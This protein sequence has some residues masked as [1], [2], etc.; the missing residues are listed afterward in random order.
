M[1]NPHLRHQLH[2]HGRKIIA[3]G[4]L[5]LLTAP[6]AMAQQTLN[7]VNYDKRR[8]HYGFTLGIFSTNMHTRYSSA[9]GESMLVEEPGKDPQ[10]T[11]TLLN[12]ESMRTTGFMLGLVLNYNSR[13]PSVSW[14]F[15]PNVSFTER[16]LRY[17]YGGLLPIKDAPWVEESVLAYT[18]KRMEVPILELPVLL[19]LKANRRGNH[20]VYLLAGLTPSLPLGKG[21]QEGDESMQ[22]EYQRFNLEATYGLGIDLFNKMFALAPEVRFSHG[23]LNQLGSK[24]NQYHQPLE[25]ANTYKFTFVLN[26]EG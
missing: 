13:N 12:I 21:K 17:T 5:F 7:M 15:L 22:V 9:L 20:R 8:F 26:F 23:L 14:R 19:K 24:E 2:L 4:L 6:L 18:L 3:L 25:R 10:Y 16:T 1:H 11:G